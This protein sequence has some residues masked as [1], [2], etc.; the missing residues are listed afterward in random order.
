[1]QPNL[2]PNLAR[3]GVSQ[4]TFARLLAW[5]WVDIAGNELSWQYWY[6][7]NQPRRGR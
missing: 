5:G 1:M 2:P 3:Q 7:E 6:A 4:E